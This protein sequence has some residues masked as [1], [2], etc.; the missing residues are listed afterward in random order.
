MPIVN[1]GI[2]AGRSAEVKEKLMQNV[3]KAVCETIDCPPEAVI[4]VIADI[5]QENWGQG[6]KQGGKN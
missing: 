1:I 2:W 5:P 4:V 3:T 6:G